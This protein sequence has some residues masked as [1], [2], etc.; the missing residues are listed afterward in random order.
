MLHFYYLVDVQWGPW[1]EMASTWLKTQSLQWSNKLLKTFD[2][3]P[4]L[5]FLT[6]STTKPKS[7]GLFKG[8]HIKLKRNDK[9]V[10]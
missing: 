1:K 5:G 9:L 3:F 10:S 4:A 6:G 7:T 8:H 2:K